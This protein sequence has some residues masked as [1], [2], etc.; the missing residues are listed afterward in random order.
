MFGKP[1]DL[2]GEKEAPNKS[3]PK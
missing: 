2:L 1:I 3:I